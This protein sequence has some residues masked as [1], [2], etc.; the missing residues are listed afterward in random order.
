MNGEVFRV[1]PRLRRLLPP[2]FEPETWAFL[3]GAVHPGDVV[4]D[5]GSFLGTYAMAMARWGARVYAFEP[6]PFSAR[7]LRRHV[8]INRLEDRVQVNEMAL[9]AAEG[10]VTLHQHGEPY[11]NAV[12]AHDPAGEQ[13]GTVEVQMT[14]VDAFC[15]ARQLQPTLIRMDVQGLEAEVLRGARETL[16]AMGERLRVVLEVHPQLWPAH[17]VSPASFDALLAE[18]G[19]RAQP[20]V[21]SEPLYTPDAHVLLQPA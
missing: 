10:T 9:G 4:L 8:Q 14:T 16:A 1:D 15:R 13:R 18:L 6:T 17:G 7:G 2:Q 21:A 12:A 3:R 19:R 20:M 11:R 5:I